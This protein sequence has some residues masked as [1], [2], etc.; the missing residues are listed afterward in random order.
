M[1]KT[2][3]RLQ[4]QGLAELP[5][6]SPVAQRVLSIVSDEDISVAEFAH[7]IEQDPV[8][9]ARIIGV[10]NSAYFGQREPVTSAEKAI[11]NALGLRLTKNLVV[12]LALASP[13]DAR[14]CSA[15]CPEHYWR[16]A[17]LSAYL[18]QHL[19]RKMG[20]VYRPLDDDAYLAGLLHGFGLLPLTHVLPESMV[21]VFGA[22]TSDD[23][24]IDV[25]RNT[26]STDHHEVGG[27]LARKWHI[28]AHI[29]RAIEHCHEPDYR[30]ADWPL[31]Q[32]T[33]YA[34]RWVT[35]HLSEA[36]AQTPGVSVSTVTPGTA[37][38]VEEDTRRDVAM[39]TVGLDVATRQA[40]EHDVLERYEDIISLARIFVQG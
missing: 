5:T 14:R 10:A 27:W 35:R 38:Q 8:M 29:V 30:G 9:L 28:P 13:F 2:D 24:L 22:V 26:F 1:T 17:M 34:A 3:V 15:F 16:D 40:I 21:T 36:D 4:V 31:V 19:S 32:V 33:G 18:A 39:A 37:R 23:N 12:A 25:E 7:V 20:A 11:F 6:F